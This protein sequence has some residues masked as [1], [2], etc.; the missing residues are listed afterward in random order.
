MAGVKQMQEAGDA[1]IV[2]LAGFLKKYGWTYFVAH[3]K[4]FYDGF[5]GSGEIP[6]EWFDL[7]DTEKAAL[8]EHWTQTMA[9]HGIGN[10]HAEFL[11]EV[12]MDILHNAWRIFCH[13]H[14]GADEAMKVAENDST[15]ANEPGA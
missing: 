9:N 10:E 4:T 6:A 7:D 13:F 11:I 8:A 3:L 12:I 14:E 5:V 1:L 2:V 15:K